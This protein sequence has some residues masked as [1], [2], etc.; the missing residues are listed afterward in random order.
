[1]TP[2]SDPRHDGHCRT[3]IVASLYVVSRSQRP[4]VPVMARVKCV[5]GG[6]VVLLDAA[7]ASNSGTCQILAQQGLF[8]VTRSTS[9]TG[10]VCTVVARGDALA[11]GLPRTYLCEQNSASFAVS[12]SSSN[13]TAVVQ[14]IVNTDGGSPVVKTV[15]VDKLF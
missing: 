1:M 13:I 12:D 5:A 6:T 3:Q 4:S 8:L 9:T 10:E 15:V 2:L 14:N 11:I 7:Y